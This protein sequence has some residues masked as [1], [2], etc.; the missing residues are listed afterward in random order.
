MCLERFGC[1]LVE[2]ELTESQPQTYSEYMSTGSTP[3]IE[4]SGLQRGEQAGWAEKKKDL[5]TAII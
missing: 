2:R 1:Q 3:G 4:S 5:M